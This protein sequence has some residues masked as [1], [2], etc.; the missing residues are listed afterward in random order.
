MKSVKS[1]FLKKLIYPMQ[2]VLLTKG[3]CVACTRKLDDI[4]NRDNR[5]NGTVR[6]ECEC[7]R[8]YIYDTETK[9]Y[10]RAMFDEV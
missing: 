2:K 1:K 4:K 7:G 8:I 6:V 5:P 9:T 3:F 10:R